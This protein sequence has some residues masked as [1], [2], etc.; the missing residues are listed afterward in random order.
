M[1]LPFKLRTSDLR[2]FCCAGLLALLALS[3]AC[4]GEDDE[5]TPAVGDAATTD[6]ADAGATAAD[7]GLA[8]TATGTDAAPGGDGGAAGDDAAGADGSSSSADGAVVE[9]FALTSPVTRLRLVPGRAQTLRVTVERRSFNG[10]I[11]VVLRD[12]PATVTG[13]TTMIMPNQTMGE[14]PVMAK[15]DAAPSVG[16][17]KVEASG[18]GVTRVIEIDLEVAGKPGTLDPTFGGMGIVTTKVTEQSDVVTAIAVRPDGKI[19]VAG[20]TGEGLAVARYLPEGGL[21]TTFAEQGLHRVALAG[22][23]PKALVLMPSGQILVAGHAPGPTTRDLLVL[24]LQENGAPDPTFGAGGLGRALIDFGHNEEANALALRS[25]GLILLAGSTSNP[26]GQMLLVRLRANGAAD[27]VFNNGGAMPIA[28]GA[29]AYAA[30][31][32]V[33]R[34]GKIVLVG[35]AGVPRNI[36]A[37]RLTSEGHFDTD[38]SMDGITSIPSSNEEIV[39]GAVLV[40]QDRL[41]VTGV[42][43]ASNHTFVAR[44]TPQGVLDPGFGIGGRFIATVSPTADAPTGGVLLVGDRIVVAGRAAIGGLASVFVLRLLE[45]GTADTGFGTNG[46]TTTPVAPAGSGASAIGSTPDSRIL[47]GGAAPLDGGD[48]FLAR[49][50]P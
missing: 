5:E 9:V 15:D 4:G 31:L 19:V 20:S 50:W 11:Q 34:D 27:T 36:V 12:L 3:P 46:V 41:V 42:D 13:G 26:A 45:N 25:D 33:Q 8:D 14:V 2:P 37:V 21:D 17:L 16:K 49:Y 23:V 43:G 39:T 32:R 40:A 1:T 10:T 35:S 6:A 28:A 44:L 29:G 38:F 22:S 7:G 47:V 30:S 18:G 48:F 24:R